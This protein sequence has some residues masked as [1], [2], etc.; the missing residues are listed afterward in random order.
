[1]PKNQPSQTTQPSVVR[2]GSA[3]F[4]RD[5]HHDEKRGM[6]LPRTDQSFLP[7]DTVHTRSIS[8]A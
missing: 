2:S 4:G 8:D 3:P 1:M 6:L 7:N 5:L